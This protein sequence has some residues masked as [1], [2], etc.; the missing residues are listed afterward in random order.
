VWDSLTA[1]EQLRLIQMLV[2]KVG[3][4]GQTGKVTVDF[5]SAEINEPCEEGSTTKEWSQSWKTVKMALAIKYEP[6]VSRRELVDYA[7][8]AGQG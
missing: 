8:I 1:R 6:M 7:D 2:A 5:R 3:Y 4:D